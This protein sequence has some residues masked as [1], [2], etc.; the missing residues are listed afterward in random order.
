MKS[1]WKR[2]LKKIAAVAITAVLVCQTAE[3]LMASIKG[4]TADNNQELDLRNAKNTTIPQEMFEQMNV[5]IEQ[6]GEIA[7]AVFDFTLSKSVEMAGEKT[8]EPTMEIETEMK[9]EIETEVETEIETEIKTEVPTETES[10]KETEVSTAMETPTK[11]E[12]NQTT[13]ETT[14]TSEM[15]TVENKSYQAA[16]SENQTGT[17]TGVVEKE[18]ITFQVHFSDFFTI[19]EDMENGEIVM[20]SEDSGENGKPIGKYELTQSAESGNIDMAVTIHVP[21]Y[22]EKTLRGTIQCYLGLPENVEK[23]SIVWEEANSRV[24][25]EDIGKLT[26]NAFRT[27]MRGKLVAKPLP[28]AEIVPSESVTTKIDGKQALQNLSTDDPNQKYAKI[29]KKAELSLTTTRGSQSIRVKVD[30]EVDDTFLEDGFEELVGNYDALPEGNKGELSAYLD[31]IANYEFLQELILPFSFGSEFTTVTGEDVKTPLTLEG[32]MAEADTFGYYELIR[33]DDGTLPTDGVSMKCILNK[34]LYTKTGVTLGYEYELKSEKTLEANEI[35]TFVESEDKITFGENKEITV[36]GEPTE[37]EGY[38]ITKEKTGTY[39]Q[40]DPYA[41]YKIEV[42]SFQVGGLNEATVEDILPVG[43][44]NH[45]KFPMLVVNRVFLKTD[46]EARRELTKGEAGTPGTYQIAEGAADT[47]ETTLCYTF[48]AGP[49][50]PG[51]VTAKKITRATLEVETMLSP[52]AL[53]MMN[54]S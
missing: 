17:D 41:N 42:K 36:A 5:T 30:A 19:H 28:K 54:S 1:K 38:R 7:A 4:I 40:T 16:L 6:R 45:K 23:L 21:K 10:T 14:Q 9:T 50:V 20:V 35:Y 32:D 46:N 44:A 47:G 3:P 48:P 2:N 51:D 15:K 33:Q 25:G 24:I 39:S 8:Q 11:E 53:L 52:T 27:P 26:E 13:E 22:R 49:A 12:K 18:E 37:A 31:N 29:F 43:S 34:K